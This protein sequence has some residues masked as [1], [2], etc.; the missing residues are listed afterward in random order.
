MPALRA[1][2]PIPGHTATSHGWVSSIFS[3]TAHARFRGGSAAP[4]GGRAPGPHH[5]ILR[6]PPRPSCRRRIGLAVG[7]APRYTD[8]PTP[9]VTEP[10]RER[11]PLPPRHPPNRDQ[12]RRRAGRR[13]LT[14]PAR[15][16]PAEEAGRTAGR[17]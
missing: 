8:T 2:C 5:G 9:M 17:V 11:L 12:G 7:P 6:R 16:R 14:P 4:P 10:R 15:H 13:G 1:T 3:A